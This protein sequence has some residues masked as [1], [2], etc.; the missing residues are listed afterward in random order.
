[1]KILSVIVALMTTIIV[2]TLLIPLAKKVGLVDS[3]GG[4]KH[5]H[6]PTP[7]VG[8]IAIFLAFGFGILLIDNSLQA[9][10]PFLAAAALLV[11]TGVLD[12]FHELT[13]RL[14]LIVQIIA[15]LLMVIWGKIELLSLGHIFGVANIEL[16]YNIGLILTVLAVVGIINA[17]NMLDGVDGLVGTVSLVQF[18]LLI[19]LAFSSGL[20]LDADVLALLVAAILG[21]LWFNFPFP[22]RKHA[23]IFM[24]DAG[25]MFL[26]FTLV[27]FM[28]YLSQLPHKAMEPVAF[29]WIMIVPLYDI[30]GVIV[31]RVLQ[32]RSI[33]QADREHIHHLLQ[34]L[35]FSKLGLVLLLSAITLVAGLGADFVSKHASDSTLLLVAFILGFITYIVISEILWRKIKNS[36]FK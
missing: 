36:N 21:Y 16:N 6:S 35:G 23:I 12:D 27:W 28:I 31:R 30:G 13:P 17:I 15:A 24:G 26:G 11:F 8:G 33:M 32:K 22:W 20:Y 18:S 25:S 7:L 3:P 14:R 2:T 4:R 29:L 10:R 5:H 1:M 9:Y 19:Y 34:H